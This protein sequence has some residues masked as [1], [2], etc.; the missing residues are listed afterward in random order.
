MN[1]V[2]IKIDKDPT[3]PNPTHQLPEIVV[4]RY[5]MKRI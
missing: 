1:T 2:T 3:D 4:C 5:Y